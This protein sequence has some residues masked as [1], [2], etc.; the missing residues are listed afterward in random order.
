MRDK[1]QVRLILH[2]PILM[3]TNLVPREKEL[4]HIQ[5]N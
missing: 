3:V 5:G 1:T 4:T 2:Q